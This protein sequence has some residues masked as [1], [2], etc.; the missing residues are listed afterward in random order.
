MQTTATKSR[1]GA[2]DGVVFQGVLISERALVQRVRR[3]LEKAQPQGLKLVK[4]RL[5]GRW[6]VVHE[7]S[8]GC[9]KVCKVPG[10]GIVEDLFT[11]A[12]T[13]GVVRPWEELSR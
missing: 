12:R 9:G 4:A 5:W 7:C 11:Y 13:L 2:G 6:L 10:Q 3:R 8:G 1:R